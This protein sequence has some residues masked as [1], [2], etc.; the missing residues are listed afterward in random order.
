M[1][2][3]IQFGKS[4]KG[5]LCFVAQSWAVLPKLLPCVTGLDDSEPSS[6]GI[7]PSNYQIPM[8]NIKQYRYLL[9]ARKSTESEERQVLS[10]GSQK[11]KINI[12]F[13]QIEIVEVLE[14]SKSAFKPYERNVFQSMIE[15][16][17]SGEAD[18][19]VAWHPDRLSRNEI[20][21][22]TITYFIRTGIIKDLKFGSYNFDNSPEGIMMLQ[23]AL[24]QSQ[25]SSSKL[26]KDV[27]RGLGTKL[28]MGIRPNKAPQGWLND[29]E[30]QRGMRTIKIDPKRFPV[31]K[32]CWD[33]M[34][35]G[36][37]TPPQILKK[38]NEEWGYRTTKSKKTGGTPLSR[39]GIYQMFT[40]K[41]YAGLIKQQDGAWTSG[42]HRPMVTL[43]EYDRVQRLLGRQGNPRAKQYDFCYKPLLICG[44][45][46]G[47]I[48]AEM[49]SKQIKST[50]ERKEYTFYHCTHNK[51]PDCKQGSIEERELTK[52][53]KAEMGKYTILPQ[54]KDWA[55]EM[56]NKYND[57]EIKERSKIHEMQADSILQTQRE[58]DNLTQMRYRELINDTEYLKEK[59]ELQSKMEK[60][61][62]ELGDTHKRAENWLELTEKTFDFITYAAYHYN[63]GSF[64]EKRTIL[65]GFGSNFFIKDKKLNMQAHEW[66]VPIDR[67]YRQLENEYLSLEPEQKALQKGQSNNLDR[68]R[69]A[70]L[71][72]KD[73][74]P[75]MTG[76]EP[77]ALPLG[78]SPIMKCNRLPYSPQRTTPQ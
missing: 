11:E 7:L 66:L 18:G 76:S 21:A 38:L 41:F 39:S 6:L 35:T 72:R 33:M 22:A 36:N 20:D 43:A 52:M 50:G 16:I 69:L 65:R 53:V 37:Y 62:E 13:P 28:K 25:Y 19:I 24:S 44:E 45:C 5:K 70:W 8:E 27:K 9:Y 60:L 68:I 74:N 14:E 40:N 30:G 67:E 64:E 75:R 15:R 57:T 58:I 77:V 12:I 51:D 46:K 73:S 26:S 49:K 23:M 4:Y 29:Y 1:G 63:E 47:S 34:L 48:T 32:K 55:L 2:A 3:V 54:F 17:K 42:A 31:L 61:K 56:L 78:D 71:G 59:K 10:I